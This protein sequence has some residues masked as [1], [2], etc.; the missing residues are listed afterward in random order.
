MHR[1]HATPVSLSH[2]HQK[3][4]EIWF[5]SSW[6]LDFRKSLRQDWSW[7]HKNTF[8]QYTL[9]AGKYEENRLALSI[10]K[11]KIQ[12]GQDKRII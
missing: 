8:S 7:S 10:F 3:I 11:Q 4:N 5:I 1:A 6:V 12:L 9:L 2:C